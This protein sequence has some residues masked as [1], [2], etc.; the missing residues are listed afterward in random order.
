MTRVTLI[1]S[2]ARWLLSSALLALVGCGPIAPTAATPPI[3]SPLT[4]KGPLMAA[5]DENLATWQAAGITRYAFTFEP[6]CF[7]DT[8]HRLV[9][10]DGDGIRIDG[11]PA[12]AQPLGPAGVPGLF[13]LVRNAI[14][15]DSASIVYDASTGVP[16]HL[17]SD[18]MHNAIDDELTFTVSGWTLVPP[19]DAKLGAI[20]TARGVWAGHRLSLYTLTVAFDCVCAYDGKTFTLTV[21]DG[22]PVVR[23]GGRRMSL[24]RVEGIP[25]RVEAV[26]DFAAS[27]A[28][29]G[30]AL[31]ELD[32]ELGYPRKVRVD[33]NKDSSGQPETLAV[34]VEPR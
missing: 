2:L 28:S 8:T 33:S 11:V 21:G 27:F 29:T 5:F 34:M 32:P 7:C 30:D 17:V 10:A 9:V 14:K 12:G 22:D 24:E 1:R 16:I 20:T 15:G 4:A 31:V 13:E 26:F 3:G 23:S 25:L 19:D 18:P 6:E